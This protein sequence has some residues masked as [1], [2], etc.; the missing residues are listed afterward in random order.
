MISLPM[1]RAF[2][3]IAVLLFALPSA[4]QDSASSSRPLSSVLVDDGRIFLIDVGGFFVS[5]LHWGASDWGLA[6]GAIGGTALTMTAD[7]WVHD[8]VSL[9][10]DAGQRDDFWDI[11]TFYGTGAFVAGTSAVT[12]A[13]GLAFGNDEV[14]VVGRLMITSLATASITTEILKY[15]M[16]RSR[17]YTGESQWDFRWFEKGD[18]RH[19]FPSGHTTAAFAMSTVLAE[20]IDKPWARVAFYGMATL[21][22]V[23]RVRNNQHWASDVLGGALIGIASG[24]SALSQEN[25]RKETGDHAGR[26]QFGVSYAGVA[27]TYRIL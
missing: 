5:P 17:P 13:A 24:F 2:P 15:A 18:D 4:A 21:T 10:G 1:L 16:G 26:L 27:V 23:A 7:G 9:P 14:R 19:S 12:Y 20:S 8:R 3:I 25:S 22:G 11:P 6:A